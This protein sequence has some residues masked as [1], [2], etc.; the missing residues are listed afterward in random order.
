METEMD[1]KP[2]ELQIMLSREYQELGRNIP[3]PLS[4]EARFV[5]GNAKHDAQL[6]RILV[7]YGI[8]VQLSGRS[9]YNEITDYRVVDEQKFLWFLLRWS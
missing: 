2:C 3:C 7:E 1:M 4:P 9:G 8:E 6:H 5:T